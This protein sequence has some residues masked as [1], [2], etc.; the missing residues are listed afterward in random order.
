MAPMARR[1][2]AGMGAAQAQDTCPRQAPWILGR[3]AAD[4]SQRRTLRRQVLI[5][6]RHSVRLEW[7]D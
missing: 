5:N 6:A 1:R 4:G 2:M 7:A 3:C